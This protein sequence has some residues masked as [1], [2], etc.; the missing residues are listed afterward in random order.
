[1]TSAIDTGIGGLIKGDR[2][3]L[4]KTI[5][6]IESSLPAH[7][8]AAQAILEQLL[9]YTGKAVRLGITGVPG[10]GKSSFIESLGMALVEKDQR[11]A[12]L[13]VDPSSVRSGGSILAD[14]TRME[15]LSADDRAFIRP[16]PSGGTL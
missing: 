13:A 9:P 15:K 11:V 2:R 7:Q 6:L 1:M 8:E 12:V 3:A 14:K 5:T 10:V 4:S 16:S